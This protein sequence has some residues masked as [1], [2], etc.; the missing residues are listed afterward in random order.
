MESMEYLK[1]PQS[2]LATWRGLKKLGVWS[3]ALVAIT[4]GLMA[5]TLT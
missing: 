4:L 5:I 3:A 2:N 1:A